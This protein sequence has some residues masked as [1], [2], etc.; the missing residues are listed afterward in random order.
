MTHAN[1]ENAELHAAKRYCKVTEEGQTDCFFDA[2]D[3]CG[4]LG[5]IEGVEAPEFIAE[6]QENVQPI[7]RENFHLVQN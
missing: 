2:V 1:L 4:G 3:N 5:E 6:L 7:S